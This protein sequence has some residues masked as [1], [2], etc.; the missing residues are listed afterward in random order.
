MGREESRRYLPGHRRGGRLAPSWTVCAPQ[1]GVLGGDS[2]LDPASE[3]FVLVAK[4][5]DGTPS[6]M[7][8]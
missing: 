3:Y 7:G 1:R 6:A 8:T 4:W 5:S 2:G